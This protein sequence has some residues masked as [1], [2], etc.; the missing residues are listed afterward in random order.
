MTTNL[1][2]PHC[3]ELILDDVV[4]IDIYPDTELTTAVPRTLPYVVSIADMAVGTPL[5]TLALSDPDALEYD[6]APTVKLTEKTDSNGRTFAHDLSVSLK[7]D[8]YNVREAERALGS[9]DCAVVYTLDDGRRLCSLP[10]PNTAS[11]TLEQ[12]LGSSA[13]STLKVQLT[14]MSALV[15]IDN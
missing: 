7:G 9:A 14:S 2:S 3:K 6:T 11:L 12:N 5:L 15:Q 1:I 10:L 13:T 4:R 8:I